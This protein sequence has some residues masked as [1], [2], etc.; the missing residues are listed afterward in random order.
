MRPHPGGCA[1]GSTSVSPLPPAPTRA[2]AQAPFLEIN[3]NIRLGAIVA[4]LLAAAVTAAATAGVAAFTAAEAAPTIRPE[5]TSAAALPQVPHSPPRA[6]RGE[7]LAGNQ[8]AGIASNYAGT[9]GWLGEATVAL[10]GALGGRYTG[11]V[12][13]FVTVCAD[14]CARL[15]I[16]DWCECY[17]GTGDQRIVDLSHPAWALVSDRPLSTGLVEVRLILED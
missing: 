16:V 17:W 10:P 8:A 6:K 7:V 1:H 2:G 5:S 9:A 4:L 3:V 15:P 14:R 12:N 13:G 11:E